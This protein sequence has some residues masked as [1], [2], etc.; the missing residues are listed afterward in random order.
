VSELKA[1]L[2]TQCPHLTNKDED[3]V[4]KYADNGDTSAETQGSQNR[5]GI[6]DQE[7]HEANT[8]YVL[9]GYRKDALPLTQKNRPKFDEW[10]KKLEP[11]K[12]FLSNIPL[13]DKVVVKVAIL[14]GGVKLT[15]I[16]GL[17]V[18]ESTSWRPDKEAYWAGPSHHG[19][20]MAKCIR[21]ICPMAKFYIARLDDSCLIERQRFTTLS[22]CQVRHL[23]VYA[24]LN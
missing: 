9:I 24:A 22:A 16:D 21:Q 2:I 12:E 7:K 18:E 13:D 11:F 19:T 3:I 17:R 5:G 20:R 8:A 14:D 6:K 1:K 4:V 10:V 23:R 15:D